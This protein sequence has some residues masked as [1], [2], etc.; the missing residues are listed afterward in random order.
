MSFLRMRTKADPHLLDRLARALETQT[1]ML[2]ELHAHYMAGKG[3]PE[4]LWIRVSTSAWANKALVDSEEVQ[5]NRQRARK[6]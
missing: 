1:E 4:S 5:A 2:R 6:A 3:I